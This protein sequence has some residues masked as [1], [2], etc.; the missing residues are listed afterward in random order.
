MAR[1]V[2]LASKNELAPIDFEDSLSKIS[3]KGADS[4]ARI[5]FLIATALSSLIAA[6]TSNAN[7]KAACSI[8]KKTARTITV[9]AEKATSVALIAIDFSQSERLTLNFIICS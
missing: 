3:C 9:T 5:S 8:T 7:A 6:Y 2:K 4:S 1:I